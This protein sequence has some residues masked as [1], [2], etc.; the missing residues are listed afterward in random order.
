MYID[1]LDGGID[2]AFF[3]RTAAQWRD[4]QARCLRDIQRHQNANRCYLD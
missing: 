4:E 1:K 2:A 3:D